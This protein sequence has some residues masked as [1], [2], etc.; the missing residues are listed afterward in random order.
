M[1]RPP[2]PLEWSKA[3]DKGGAEMSGSDYQRY[4]RVAIALHWAIAVCILFNLSLGFFMEGFKQPLRGTVVGLHVSSGITALT[5]TVVRLIWRL[6]H[7]PPPFPAE[8][9]LWERAAAHAGHWFIYFMMFAMPLTGWSIISAHPPRPGA[10][11]M[12]W[13]TLLLPPISK[14][15]H[16]EPTTQKAAHETFV[17]LHT[18]GGW[19]FLALLLLHVG[20]ALKHQF[21]DRQAEFARMGI[22]GT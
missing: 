10:G 21:Y 20:A 2:G 17:Q 5:L 18:I 4:T 1:R 6:G 19:I 9:A 12:I 11:A 8:M 16:L 13:G 15:S 22:G 7:E 3:E 14:I